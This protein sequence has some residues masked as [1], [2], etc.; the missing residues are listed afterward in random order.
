MVFNI[1]RCDRVG[2]ILVK[3]NLNR[4]VDVL[5]FKPDII[6]LFIFSKYIRYFKAD[7]FF[8]SGHEGESL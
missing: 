4:A 7:I 2:W 6:S 8:R 5:Y 1:A 3:F